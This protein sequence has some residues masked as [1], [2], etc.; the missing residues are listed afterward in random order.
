MAARVI[1]SD[2]EFEVMI[3]DGYKVEI[4]QIVTNEDTGNSAVVPLNHL[5]SVEQLIA[6]RDVVNAALKATGNK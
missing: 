5:L 2:E 6:L 3:T 4:N 1:I